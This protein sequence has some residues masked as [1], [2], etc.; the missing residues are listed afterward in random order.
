LALAMLSTC[1]YAWYEPEE[2]LGK[3]RELMA[4]AMRICENLGE[5]NAEIYHLCL[6]MRS[7]QEGGRQSPSLQARFTLHANGY[8][9]DLLS[10]RVTVKQCH[11]LIAMIRHIVFILERAPRVTVLP[12]SAKH[13]VDQKLLLLKSCYGNL[14]SP[15]LQGYPFISHYFRLLLIG[16]SA[17]MRLA[18]GHRDKA[19]NKAIRFVDLLCQDMF[20]FVDVVFYAERMFDILISARLYEH[21][22]RLMSLFSAKYSS[23]KNVEAFLISASRKLELEFSDAEDLANPQSFL[24]C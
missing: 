23:L 19:L 18:L 2:A 3:S 4:H 24:S 20:P 7:W 12:P 21:A 16:A 22:K 6:D 13:D 14:S 11:H 10:C 15:V 17:E 8:P 9:P 5:T 1:T